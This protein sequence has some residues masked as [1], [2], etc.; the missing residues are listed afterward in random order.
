MPTA[1]MNLRDLLIL[2]AEPSAYLRRIICQMLKAFGANKLIEADTVLATLAILAENKVDILLCDARLPSTG[3][4]KLIRDL[5]LN[6]QNQNRTV[7]TILM[8]DESGEFWVK[9]AR[10]VGVNMVIAKPISP[11]SLYDRMSWVAF[12]PRQF[13]ETVSYFGPDRR[14][15][16]EGFP[17]G[18]GRRGAD[19]ASIGSEVGPALSQDDV[20]NLFQSTVPGAG[21]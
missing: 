5:R 14:F 1:A 16:I 11:K 7:P 13:V 18:I 15:K 3:G 19:N 4:L 17:S 21:R 12:H 6:T 8:I 9:R 10:D 2:V 20:D